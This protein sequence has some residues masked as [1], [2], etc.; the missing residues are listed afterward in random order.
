MRGFYKDSLNCDLAAL[1][2]SEKSVAARAVKLGLRKTKA[3]ILM[4]AQAT[5]FKKG[6]TP[7]NKGKKMPYNANCARTQFKKHNLPHNTV[8][9]GTEVR[10]RDGYL[11]RKVS[12]RRDIP[13]RRNWVYVHRLLWE[14]HNGP[15]PNG[16]IVTFRDGDRTN[17]VIENLVLMSFGENAK[18]NRDR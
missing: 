16:H 11:K 17:I 12:D 9:V 15:I 5:W 8:P 7:A 3:Y 10:D 18:R 4:H 6:R 14:Q 2:R 1:G 13:S